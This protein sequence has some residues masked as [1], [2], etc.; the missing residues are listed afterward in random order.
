[1]FAQVKIHF[2]CSLSYFLGTYNFV[3]F[4]QYIGQFHWYLAAL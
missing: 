1:M 4:N 3:N 2:S